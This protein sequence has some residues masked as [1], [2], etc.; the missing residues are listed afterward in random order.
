MVRRL[1]AIAGL[2]GLMLVICALSTPAQA[3]PAPW[4]SEKGFENGIPIGTKIT[5]DNWQK[6]KDFM[7][8]AMIYLFQ[9]DHFWHMPKGIEIDV[10]PTRP[11][12]PPRP[13]RED[14]EKYGTQTSLIKTPDGGYIPKGYVAGFP[15]PNPFAGDKSLVGAKM[16]WN[17][18][19]RPAPRVEEAPNASY[20]LDQYANFTRTANTDIVFSQL[21]HL[22]EPGFPRDTPDNNGY[23]FAE[24]IEQTAPEQG[25]Y[26]TSL[27]LTPE[28]VSKLDELYLY[29]PSL[30]R[31]LRQSEAARCAPLFGTDFT[32]E[33]AAEGAPRQGNLFDIKYLGTKKI[34]SLMHGTPESFDTFGTP[35]Q[36][37]PRYYYFG[38]KGVVP[39]P[40]PGSGEWEV[41]DVYMVEMDRLP[42]LSRGYC[43]GKRILYLDKDE[44]FPNH[45]EVYDRAG[46]LYKWIVVFAYPAILPGL[47]LDGQ[48]VTITGPN[49]GYVVNFEDD[50]ATVFIGLHVC[51]DNECGPRGYLDVSRYA[52]P[53]GLMKIQQ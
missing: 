44:Y 3:Q 27:D 4:K 2:L 30:R 6:Y 36:L 33:D 32:Y 21:T 20:T 22:S 19:Y 45:T 26:T 29:I 23:Y 41:R 24:Y 13:F 51:V 40:N 28:D 46:K 12:P 37:D 47:G 15:F 5:Q 39:F 53:E 42:S 38:S 48:E 49:T 34:L 7:P 17:N 10:G 31:S 43:Y 25:K 35:T 11:I 18:F 8:A 16:Y 1:P 50:H 14:S 52:S 9:G